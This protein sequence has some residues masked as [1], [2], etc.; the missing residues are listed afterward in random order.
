VSLVGALAPLGK[1]AGRRR[2]WLVNVTLY[3]VAGLL[4]SVLVGLALG[5]AG[6]LL[7]PRSLRAIGLAATLLVAALAAAR[8]SG[9][10]SIPFP[11]V[12][13]QTRDVW[14][15]R[16]PSTVAATLW[17]LDLGLV[18]TTWFTFSGTWLLV[19]AAFSA[20]S[21]AYGAALFAA[22]WSG[23]ALSVWVAPSLLRS[24]TATPTL[25]GAIDAERQVFRWV[26]VAGVA[27]AGLTIV[28]WLVSMGGS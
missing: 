21:P 24:A 16:F 13:R 28:V 1:V 3:T 14:A 25:V 17:G 2:R 23:R 5:A 15:K 7:W 8:E 22:Y 20:G 27:A 6:L 19:A 18:F 10:I 26:H 9:A 12:R 4:A 11:Q